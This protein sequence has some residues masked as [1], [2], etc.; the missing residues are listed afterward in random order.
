[1]SQVT[2]LLFGRELCKFGIYQ[3]IAAVEAIFVE[4]ALGEC[5]ESGEERNTLQRKRVQ[6]CC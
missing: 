6:A 2:I 4:I 3:H 5:L 1:M